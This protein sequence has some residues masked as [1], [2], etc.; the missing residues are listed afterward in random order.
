[1]LEKLR[2]LEQRHADLLVAVGAKELAGHALEVLP[3]GNLRRQHVVHAAHRLDLGS[4]AQPP[5]S[6][7]GR[8]L[9]C[10]AP[11]GALPSTT[12]SGGAPLRVRALSATPRPPIRRRPPASYTST[13]LASE[14]FRASRASPGAAGA[15]AAVARCAP[16]AIPTALGGGASSATAEPGAGAAPAGGRVTGCGFT[17]GRVTR[18]HRSPTAA[19]TAH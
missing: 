8:P 13:Q 7:T 1:A 14:N 16:A 18:Q 15:P 6:G 12:R 9:S 19:N 10:T 4:H 17:P 3:G 5:G 2:V 11:A